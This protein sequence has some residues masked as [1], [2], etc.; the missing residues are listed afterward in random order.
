MPQGL[1]DLKRLYWN[2][3]VFRTGPRRRKSPYELQG[4]AVP[5]R[6][7]GELLRL[8]PEQLRRQLQVANN[9]AGRAATAKSVRAR[10]CSLRKSPPGSTSTPPANTLGGCNWQ[11]AQTPHAGGMLV[12]LGDASVRSVQA[13]LS[14][15]TWRRAITPADGGV[16]A[17]DW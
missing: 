1:L 7:W 9:A 6:D 5:T 10:R 4:L 12:L 3:R 2:C 13:S 14:V 16:L 8:P 15:T 17:N 11:L